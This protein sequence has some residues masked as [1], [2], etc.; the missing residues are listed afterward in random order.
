MFKLKQF[1]YGFIL[2][3]VML[4]VLPFQRALAE[5]NSREQ[6][7]I[8]TVTVTARKQKENIQEVPVAITVFN[9]Q[10]IEDKQIQAVDDIGDVVPNLVFISEGQNGLKTP[11]MR[12]LNASSFTYTTT[13]GLY[14]DGVPILSGAGFESEILDIERIEVLRGPQGSLYGKNTET[15]VINII[16]KQPGNTFRAKV[17]AKGGALLSME[18]NDRMTGSFS[19]SLSGPIVTDKFYIGVAGRYYS[20]DGF[21]KNT[22]T[23]DTENDRKHWF[24]RGHLRWTPTAKLD[25]SFIATGTEFDDGAPSATNTDI[26]AAAMGFSAPEYRKVS[27]NKEGYNQSVADSQALKATYDINDALTLTSVTTR[28]AYHDDT[29]ADWDFTTATVN[30]CTIDRIYKKISQEL[31]LDYA[32][33]RLKWLVGAYYDRD[34]KDVGYETISDFANYNET[35]ARDY[36]ENAHAIF[37]NLVY[38]VTQ[39]LGAVAGLRW[40]H[41]GS[42]FIDHL[43]GRN[44]ENNWETLSPKAG[45]EYRISP[46]IM[47]YATVSKGHRSGGFNQQ[48]SVTGTQYENFD[49][50]ELCSY[51]V[52]IK[53][54]LFN[55]R[56]ILNAT[57]YYMDISDMQVSE[58]VSILSTYVTNAAKATGKG[59]ELEIMGR[60]TNGL[61]LSAGFGYSNVEFDEFVDA[62]GDYAGNKNPLAPEYTFNLGA[63]YRHPTGFTARVDLIGCGKMYFD[64]ANEYSRNPYEIVNMKVG[65]ETEHFDIYF[66]GKNIFDQDYTS[67]GFFGGY[68]TVYS[69]PGEVGLEVA[70]RF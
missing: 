61:T 67:H 26:G 50:E 4:A 48:Q 28:R 32:K 8:E 20:K 6:M 42:E 69:D 53:S 57:A 29:G 35:T 65:Y 15:G 21:I 14:M 30:H 19:A 31:R 7:E 1:L 54:V 44:F 33:D 39:R 22:V 62:W 64:K 2:T 55:K 36:E 12:G 60:I 34:D 40:E 58:A 25:I 5:E 47:T 3:L 68:Y 37:A 10:S 16:T 18:T 70:Y 46:D 24:G 23:G 56:L 63:H 41:Q 45:L 49:T 11:S 51:E 66:Y 17:T 52:G 27:S 38:P 43:D 13:M 59:V 9:G